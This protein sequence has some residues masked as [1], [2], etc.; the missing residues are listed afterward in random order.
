VNERLRRPSF[1]QQN[2]VSEAEGLVLATW[3]RADVEGE[4][5]KATLASTSGG[6]TQASAAIWEVKRA[7]AARTHDQ[8]D[9]VPAAGVLAALETALEALRAPALIVSHGGEIVFSNAPAR[10]L[11][12]REPTVVGRLSCDASEGPRADWEVTPIRG[13]RPRGWSLA[14]WRPKVAS[15][16]MRWKLTARQ[17]EVLDLVARGMTNTSIAEVLSI[18]LGT[19]EFHISA[20]FDKVGVSTRAAL[21]ARVMGSASARF[22]P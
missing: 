22:P 11:A 6:V 15:A 5:A 21:I 1:I 20:I 9:D 14:I 18:R 8:R 10:E 7:P 17:S 3:A 16:D 12:A 4:M 19:V 13:T 2:G